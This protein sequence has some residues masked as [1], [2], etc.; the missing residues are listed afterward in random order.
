MD[1]KK[2][3]PFINNSEYKNNPTIKLFILVK[4]KI[5]FINIFL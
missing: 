2:N 3:S 4:Y 1:N 5:A